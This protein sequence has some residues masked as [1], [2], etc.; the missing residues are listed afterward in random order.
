MKLDLNSVNAKLYRW[1][2]ATQSMPQSLC[3]Y[4]WKLLIAWTFC[5]PYAIITAPIRN[6]LFNSSEWD[7]GAQMIG[8]SLML[9]S[10]IGVI[11][12]MVY[13]ITSL[14]GY[15]PEKSFLG[16][17]QRIG[18]VTFFTLCV[19]GLLVVIILLFKYFIEKKRDKR[20]RMIWSTSEE[21]YILNPDYRGDTPN[22]LLEF[23]KA[24]YNKYC[25]KID[26]LD[27]KNN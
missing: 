22:L 11:I 26:W 7:N 23:I 4:F 21:D 1:F 13:S 2:Y 12:S 3:P 25:P 10:V 6:K 18:V 9:W 20:R 16:T 15:Y 17:I 27:P 24:K 14:W 5:V 8:L 19:I